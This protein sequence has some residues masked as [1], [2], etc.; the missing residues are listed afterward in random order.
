MPTVLEYSKAFSILKMLVQLWCR[1]VGGWLKLDSFLL[2]R[3]LEED[4]PALPNNANN[5]AARDDVPAGNEADVVIEDRDLVYDETIPLLD[6]ENAET[7]A[8]P[9]NLSNEA[10]SSAQIVKELLVSRSSI[11]LSPTLNNELGNNFNNE[12]QVE[13]QPV[14]QQPA[15]PVLPP[16]VQPQRQAVRV[17][18]QR[19][20]NHLAARH[21]ALLMMRDMTDYED[22]ECPNMFVLRIIVLLIC[23]SIT[24][25]AISF[26]MFLLPGWTYLKQNYN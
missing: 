15:P 14:V 25:V 1:V 20:E 19:Q 18:Q 3:H 10:S 7:S 23:L 8:E 13:P 5:Q 21:Q 17:Q 2:P 26:L 6:I 11:S 16:P 4:T 12:A 22:Y 9:L 24:A